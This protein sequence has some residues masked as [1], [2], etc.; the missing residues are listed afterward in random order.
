MAT[1]KRFD[2]QKAV[3][4]ECGQA[5]GNSSALT[6]NVGDL[7]SYVPATNI[8][9]K[10]TKASEVSTALGAGYKVY[11]IAQGDAVT[12]K[13]G[14]EYKTYKIG[15]TVTI[16]AYSAGNAKTALLVGYDVTDVNNIDGYAAE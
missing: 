13:S 1:F 12:N 3:Q 11:L 6:L 16:P 4:F 2:N 14:T 15:K 8:V 7:V 9:A 10:I 5:S